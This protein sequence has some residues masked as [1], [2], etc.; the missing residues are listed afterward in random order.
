MVG[1]PPEDKKEK[2]NWC[3]YVLALRRKPQALFAHRVFLTCAD[4][5]EETL[6]T[7]L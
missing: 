3:G 5:S 2:K 7:Q 1:S 6:N 4:V